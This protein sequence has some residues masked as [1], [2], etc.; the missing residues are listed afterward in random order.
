MDSFRPYR[1]SPINS[2]DELI[3]VIQH[4]HFACY[5]LCKNSLGTILPNAGNVGVFCHYD[6]EFESLKLIRD[7][8]AEPSENP[9]LKYFTLLEPI[10]IE[11][12]GDIPE[13]TYTHLYIRNPDPYRYQMGDIVFYLPENEYQNLRQEMLSG[14]HIPGARV[15]E[16]PDLDM[17][18]LYNPDID[19]LGYVSTSTMSEK[20]RIK[21]SDATKL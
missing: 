21:L 18:E 8:M 19:A 13:T 2:K 3:K 5:E 9:E 15:F 1:F 17:I 14:K 7:T 11:A 16:R 12:Q 4:I 10:V 20:V 6:D